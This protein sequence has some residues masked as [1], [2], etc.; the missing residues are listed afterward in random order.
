MY[1]WP[2]KHPTKANWLLWYTLLTRCI[3][4]QGS[5]LLAPLGPWITGPH[6]CSK[7]LPL[8]PISNLL[9]KPGQA[10][11]MYMPEPTPHPPIAKQP[12]SIK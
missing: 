11:G 9:D 5:S 3:C 8:D 12:T 1:I 7:W 10:C 4:S 2:D 6:Q